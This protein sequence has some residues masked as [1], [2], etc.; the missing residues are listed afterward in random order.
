[1]NKIFI[2][3]LIGLILSMTAEYLLQLEE[4]INGIGI[5][6]AI[7]FSIAFIHDFLFPEELTQKV[8]DRKE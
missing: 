1:M 6:I 5:I 3:W 8:K 7:F 4:G 2:Y